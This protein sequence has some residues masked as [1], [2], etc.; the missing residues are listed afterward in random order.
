MMSFNVCGNIP[1]IV[2]SKSSVYATAL[3]Y[4]LSNVDSMSFTNNNNYNFSVTNLFCSVTN[5]VFVSLYKI[6]TTIFGAIISNIYIPI[7]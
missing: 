5:L 4:D 1:D 6:F 3:T 7:S 2:I